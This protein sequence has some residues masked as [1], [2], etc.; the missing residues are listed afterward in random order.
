MSIVN[1]IWLKNVVPA[2]EILQMDKPMTVRDLGGMTHDA[3]EFTI[4]DFYLPNTDGIIAHFRH[5]IHIVEGLDAKML[6]GMDVSVPEGFILDF[7][8]E[9]LTL[10]YCSGMKVQILIKSIPSTPPM[11][12]F[13]TK[14]TIVPP[15]SRKL[16]PVSPKKDYKLPEYDLIYE[17]IGNQAFT[18]FPQIISGNCTSVL[19]QN[20]TGLAV[21][22]P[23]A[24]LIGQIVETEAD[25][26]TRVD[27]SDVFHLM[28]F[29]NKDLAYSRVLAKE[30]LAALADITGYTA[31]A[32]TTAPSS[33]F[34]FVESQ[35]LPT[36][37]DSRKLQLD[38]C[39]NNTAAEIA[40]ANGVTAYGN[41]Q[42]LQSIADLI[43]EFEAL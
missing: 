37:P 10:P 22:V 6:L 3:S 1:R 19:V 8:P 27:E 29:P 15:H 20:E 40:L 2:A 42:Q 13:V 23:E 21:Q 34:P 43:Q 41:P 32:L 14:K 9:T 4:I 33:S 30:S 24:L 31:S 18:A 11:P 12:V 5:E 17:P 39:P 38:S 7:S 25:R 36:G 26:M 16:V 35:A 28:A